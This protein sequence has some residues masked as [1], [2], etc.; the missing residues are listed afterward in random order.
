MKIDKRIK[1][2]I[3]CN[4]KEILIKE[5]LYNNLEEETKKLLKLYKVKITFNE[6]QKEFICKF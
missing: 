1:Q 2:A 6:K 5:E 4:V 3:D